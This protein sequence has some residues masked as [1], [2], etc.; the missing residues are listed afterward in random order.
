M[1]VKMLGDMYGPVKI[2]R[3]TFPAGVVQRMALEIADNYEK[4]AEQTDRWLGHELRAK[5]WDHGGTVMECAECGLAFDS[6]ED[7]RN[8]P[9]LCSGEPLPF[10]GTR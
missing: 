10:E 5:T 1:A 6:K 7:I 3:F 4:A 9:I 2:L 8:N